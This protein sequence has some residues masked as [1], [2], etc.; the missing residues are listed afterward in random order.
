MNTDWCHSSSIN[1][2]GQRKDIE[3][4]CLIIK[5]SMRHMTCILYQPFNEKS[6]YLS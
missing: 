5:L 2:F 6:S 1:R 3:W 4:L